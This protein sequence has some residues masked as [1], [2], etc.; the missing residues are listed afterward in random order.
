MKVVDSR[1]FFKKGKVVIRSLCGKGKFIKERRLKNQILVSGEII[2][3]SR[4]IF[5][6]FM[7]AQ[8]QPQRELSTREQMLVFY[9]QL[10]RPVSSKGV[11]SICN[12]VI[13]PAEPITQNGNHTNCEKG[14]GT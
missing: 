11:C 12:L 9:Q 1:S 4:F 13:A 2:I 10:N 7:Q 3:N 14:V 8:P 6:G 5:G